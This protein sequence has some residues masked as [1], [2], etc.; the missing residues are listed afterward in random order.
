MLP[1]QLAERPISHVRCC[2]IIVGRFRVRWVVGVHDDDKNS[3]SA[4]DDDD[5]DAMRRVS[6]DFVGGFSAPVGDAHSVIYSF[7]LSI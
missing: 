1:A 6:K 7:I 3:F 2:L 4:N 5:D